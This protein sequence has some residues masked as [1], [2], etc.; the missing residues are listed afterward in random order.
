MEELCFLC[1]PYRDVIRKRRGLE[2]VDS[3]F[4][5]GVGKERTSAGGRGIAIVN[6][7][8]WK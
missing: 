4:C 3:Q 7:K 6:C 8:V 5:T 1:G 2:L